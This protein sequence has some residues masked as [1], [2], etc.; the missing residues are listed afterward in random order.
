MTLSNVLDY[1]PTCLPD[2]NLEI[3]AEILNMET[4]PWKRGDHPMQGSDIT[5]T[6]LL[7]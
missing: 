2:L 7:V 6:E 1:K 5:W 3:T 4:G